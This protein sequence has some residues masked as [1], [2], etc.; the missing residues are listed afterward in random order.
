MGVSISS[1][2]S[3]VP[4]GQRQSLYIVSFIDQQHQLGAK[5]LPTQISC[6]N[7]S[8]LL[9][10]TRHS[11]SVPTHFSV[12]CVLSLSSIWVSCP[13][14]AHGP[15]YQPVAVRP[16]PL[17]EFP[18]P[19]GLLPNI[20]NTLLMRKHYVSLDVLQLRSDQGT[21]SQPVTFGGPFSTRPLFFQLD[22]GAWLKCDCCP[23]VVLCRGDHAAAKSEL[24]RATFFWAI[25]SHTCST[26]KALS[27]FEKWRGRKKKV[28]N[29][30]KGACSR[31]YPQGDGPQALF[32]LWGEGVLL[33]RCP[34]GGG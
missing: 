5:S 9:C 15:L 31:N 12:L 4:D 30:P 18:P 6:H 24:Y 14:A 8:W 32:V 7:R 28:Y 11:L 2:R 26:T 10:L 19:P 1:P 16:E 20:A 29:L 25:F 23:T 21:V 34:S 22:L 33:T 3:L 17:K 13:L 27:M